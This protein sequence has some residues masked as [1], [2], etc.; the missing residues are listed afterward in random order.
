MTAL[1]TLWTL[2]ESV[3]LLRIRMRMHAGIL[4]LLEHN[5]KVLS[6]MLGKVDLLPILCRFCADSLS[7]PGESTACRFSVDSLSIIGKSCAFIANVMHRP[8]SIL[9]RFSV[10]FRCADSVPILCRLSVT[11]RRPPQNTS[12]RCPIYWYCLGSLPW[13]TCLHLLRV[14]K[15]NAELL[16]CS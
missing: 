6:Q 4:V 15:T 7:T 14:T 12:A 9:C 2:I 13:R 10:D 5:R 8:L 16:V 3:L 11:F 1:V